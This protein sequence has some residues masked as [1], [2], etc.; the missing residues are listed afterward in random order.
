MMNRTL[1]ALAALTVLVLKSNPAEAHG[2]GTDANG[3]HT[4]HKTGDYHCHG[5]G[6]SRALK[7]NPVHAENAQA[8]GAFSCEGRS[9]RDPND[10][11]YLYCKTSDGYGINHNGVMEGVAKTGSEAAEAIHKMESAPISAAPTP[12]K[13]SAEGGDWNERLFWLTLSPWFVFSVLRF[14]ATLIHKNYLGTLLSVPLSFVELLIFAPLLM[15]ISGGSIGIPA[16]V[17]IWG[18]A[19]LFGVPFECLSI[20]GWLVLPWVLTGALAAVYAQGFSIRL[21]WERGY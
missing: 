5:G 19:Y 20:D 17:V 2:G 12:K 13:C 16:F 11:S 18:G 7:S 3:C 14:G 6:R 15:L 4:N 9:F 21:F 8:P 10:G 1:I